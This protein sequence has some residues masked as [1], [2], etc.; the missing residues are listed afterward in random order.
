MEPRIRAI[1]MIISSQV[2]F[3]LNFLGKGIYIWS[4]KRTYTG[5]WSNNKMHG[6]GKFTW[7]DGKVYEGNKIIH[8]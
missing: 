3:Y 1:L 2:R 8:M 5:G 4:D 6:N 7:P